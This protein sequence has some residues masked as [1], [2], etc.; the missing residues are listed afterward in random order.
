[1]T[2]VALTASAVPVWAVD[3]N[4]NTIEDACDLDCGVALGPCDVPGCGLSADCDSNGVPDECDVADDGAGCSFPDLLLDNSTGAA[5]SIFLGP[6]DN[7]FFGLGG[8]IVTWELDCGFVVDGAGPD[9]TIYEYAPGGPEFHQVEDVLVSLDGVN[10]FSV[11]S[12]ED[13]GNIQL[14]LGP[15]THP[16]TGESVWLLDADIDENGRLMKH[17]GDLVKHK[18]TGGTHPYDIHEYLLL[19]H[20]EIDLGYRLV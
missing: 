11:K 20:E 1:M 17:F 12:T 8:Q 3:C 9:F 13:Y 7:T 19:A 16:T 4:T 18:F 6:P 5:D 2:V 15:G 14:T 10:F